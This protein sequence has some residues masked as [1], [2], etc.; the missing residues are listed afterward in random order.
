MTAKTS[1][2]AFK[3]CCS[4]WLLRGQT[5]INEPQT[6]TRQK[7]ERERMKGR[8]NEDVREGGRNEYE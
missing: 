4:S 7:G 6:L 2:A 5:S 3:L 8:R 1:A